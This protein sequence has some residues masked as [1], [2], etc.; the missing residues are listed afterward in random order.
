MIMRYS[1]MRRDVLTAGPNDTVSKSRRLIDRVSKWKRRTLS[2]H[3]FVLRSSVAFLL[4]ALLTFQSVPLA[5]VA[6]ATS[7]NR[8]T[9]THTRRSSEKPIAP[10]ETIVVYGPRRFDRTGMLTKATDEFTLPAGA[11]APFNVMIQNGDASGSGRVLMGTV[12]LNGSVL[13]SSNELNL[14]VPSLTVPVTPLSQN[15]IEVVFF[16][17]HPSFLT[18]TVTA[19]KHTDATPPSISDFNPK[20]G[21]VG[22]SVTIVGTNLVSNPGNP[23]VTFAG[24]NNTRLPASITTA[25]ASQVVTTV[26]NGAVTGSIQLTTTGGTAQTNSVFK[27]DSP[28]DFQLTVS[29][30]AASAVQRGT[31]T[32]VVTVTS[33]QTNFTQLASLSVSGLPAGVSPGFNP[34]QITAGANSTLSLILAHADLAPGSYSFIISGTAAVEGAILVR[35]VPATLVV[36]AAGQTSLAGRVLNTDQEPIMGA[37][38][39]LDGKTATT[40][41]AGAFILSGVTAGPARPVMIDGRT[42]S[43]PNRT[44]PVI[45]EPANIVVGQ[46]NVI[47]FNFYLPPI[48]VHTETEVVPGQMTMAMN[49]RVPELEMMIPAGANLRNRDNTPV[50][51]V[52]I[53]PLPVDRTPTPLPSN[54]GTSVV[55]T[56][57]PGGAIADTSM[58]IVYPNLSGADPGTRIELYAFNHDTV[59]WYVYGYGRVSNDGRTISPEIDPSTGKPYGLRDFSW[60]FPNAAPNGNS[61]GAGSGG[62]GMNNCPG[63]PPPCQGQCCPGGANIGGNPSNDNPVSGGAGSISGDGGNF[64]ECPVDLSTGQKI[65]IETD[66]AFEGARGGLRLSRIHTSDLP[67]ACD[68][69]PFG[70]GTTHNYAIRLTGSFAL[71]GAGRVVMPTEQLGRL[72]SYARTDPDGT[73]VFNTL[74]TT[75]QLGDVVRKLTNGTFEY[76]YVHGGLLRFDSSGRLAA[77][78]DRNGNTTTLSY[79]GSNLIAITDV[80]GRS[81]T[82][83]YDSSG[84]ITTAT[85][86]IGRI[87]RYTYEGTP[88]IAGAPGLT[89]VTDPANGVTRLS[90]ATG[91]RLAQVI[92]PRGNVA[93]QITYDGNGRVTRQSFADGEFQ[94]YAYEFSGLTVTGAT[95]TD[96][97]NRTETKRFNPAGYVVSRSDPLGQ[98]VKLDR[99]ILTNLPLSITGSCGCLEDTRQFDNRGNLTLHTDRLG[100]T[101]KYEYDPLV[102]KVSSLTDELGRVTIYAY[103]ARGNLTSITN[104]LNQ[105]TTYSYDSLGQLTSITD[106]LNHTFHLE[107][108]NQGN[109]SATVDALGNRSTFEYDGLSRRTATIDGLGRRTAVSYDPLGRVKSQTDTAGKT[110]LLTYDPNGNVISITDALNQ[111]VSFTYDAKDRL[112]STV[113]PLGRVTRRTYND[114]DELTTVTSPLGRVTSYAYDPRGLLVTVTDALGNMVSLTY[115]S[116]GNLSTLTDQRGNKTTFIYDDLSRMIRRIDPL[117]HD[118]I[119]GYDAASNV[120]EKVDRMGRR[121]VFGYDSLNRPNHIV[122]P[123]AVV[124]YSYDLAGRLT[125]IDDT[126]GGTIDR[127]YDNANRLVSETTPAGTI[128]YAYNIANQRFSIRV[129]DRAPISYAY[130]S[131]GRL[132]S[133]VQGGETFTYTYDALSRVASLQRPNGVNTA[134]SFDPAGELTRITHTDALNQAIED[135]TQS[136]NADGEIESIT[137]L[138]SAQKLTTS[139]TAAAANAANRIA[140]F[141]Q[142]TFSF[143]DE[144][145]TTSRTNLEG[146]TNF[147]WDARGRLIRTTLPSGQVVSY[148]YDALGRRLSRAVGASITSFVY[149]GSEVVLDKGNEGSS[150]DYVNGLG[151]DNKLSQSSSVP[152]KL[153]FLQDHLGSTAVLT[154]AD[155]SVIERSQYEA[156]GNSTGS[157]FTRYG[158][159]GR[160]RDNANGL[161]YYRARYYDPSSQRFVSEDP[162]RFDSG[163]YN[164]YVYVGN[165]PINRTDP[166]GRLAWLVPAAIVGLIGGGFGAYKEGHSAYECGARGWDLASAISRGFLAGG[167]G[168]IAGLAAAALTANPLVGAAV[169][170]AVDSAVYD[171]VNVSFGEEVSWQQAGEHAL[172]G[173]LTGPVAKVIGPAVRGGSNFNPFKSPRIS[174]PKALQ[175]YTNES[176]ENLLDQMRENGSKSTGRKCRPMFF[177]IP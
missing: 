74:G 23:A 77:L 40:D 54:V 70:R 34:A 53:T 142:A 15:T 21:P 80:V 176:T 175:L 106:P 114:K 50:T 127:S 122:Y 119:T 169:G 141:G 36:V 110:T 158:F 137:S 5:K 102:N 152:G 115:D 17:R 124:N 28:Q 46:A 95:V 113:D 75:S 107:Y 128:S 37:T 132:Q 13:L 45:T 125:H 149:D 93:K 24:P 65:E 147:E 92:D 136:F 85:D 8:V 56:S 135:F 159:T 10:D 20:N 26:P 112:I 171:L 160:E 60:H 167:V 27:V 43:A 129:D 157:S 145:E 30:A 78:V 153:Y 94:R 62:G 2:L 57:Q 35:T 162:L 76:R 168:A 48:D 134:Y 121:T 73:Y 39:S 12:R 165:N 146:V 11:L 55:Y 64:T 81:I 19:T 117:G 9:E 72:F 100:Q 7:N 144:G 14:Q 173:A 105:I 67:L 83:A 71:G 63:C 139:K 47:P 61:G 3:R 97:L 91:G 22:T 59:Q 84:R 69:C 99:D 123:D 109:V 140:Q 172:W 29:P 108:D 131:A 49:P 130:D 96:S 154:G 87:W 174:G 42:A 177:I 155:G 33:P 98:T 6:R 133:I 4:A 116:K 18:I 101:V 118:T 88:G 86:P 16:S 138:A 103:D 32:Q 150:V 163:D 82:L 148:V 66:I 164:F 25:T 120:I 79:A 44:Y 31:A 1:R 38:V 166:S 126:Q 156:F 89:T 111:K 51:R 58:P 90:Y 41:A 52:S 104:A 151:T 170:G 68:F 143:N 161:L